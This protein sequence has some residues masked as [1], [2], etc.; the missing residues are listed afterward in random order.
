MAV[1]QQGERPY[2]AFMPNPTPVRS[3]IILPSENQTREFDAKL[4]QAC[5]LAERGHMVVVGA[6]HAIHNAIADFAPGIYVAKDFRKPSERILAL[7][8]GLGHSIVAWDEEGL[9]QPLPALYYQRRYSQK[10]IAHV[11][12]CFAWGPA[13]RRLMEGAPHWPALPIHNTGNPRL[14]LLRPELRGFHAPEVARLQKAYGRFVLFDTNFASFNPAVSSVA[15]ILAGQG[16]DVSPYLAGR[17][18]LF[19]RWKKLVPALAKAIAPVK[20]IIRPHPAESHAVWQNLAQHAANIEVVHSGSALAWILAAEAM[21]HSGCTTGLEAYFMGK[22]A[23]SFRPEA[24]VPLAHDLPDSLSVIVETE[25]ALISTV[26]DVIA[27]ETD[28]KG[29]ADQDALAD[30]AAFARCGPLAVDL[31]AEKLGALT[32]SGHRQLLSIA[33]ARFRQLEKWTTGLNPRHKTSDAVNALRYPGVTLQ[34]AQD[35]LQLFASVLGRFDG[36]HI[37]P[38]K[39]HIFVVQKR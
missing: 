34:E 20:L 5:V 14:D 3:A 33:K 13:N 17:K 23:I 26:Q 22:P 24:L 29:R 6:R 19:E 4:L 2:L 1:A 18:R 16:S 39:P 32:P 12:H 31:I 8:A 37:R 38:L 9:V 11:Q 25:A 15:P 30:D 35:K 21:L 36:V 28:L 27:G 10:S 7:I